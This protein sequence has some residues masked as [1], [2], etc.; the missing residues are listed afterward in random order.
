MSRKAFET[1]A[2]N[3]HGFTF[4][5]A[6]KVHMTRIQSFCKLKMLRHAQIQIV[7]S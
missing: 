4:L 5:E 6:M 2:Q 1:N 3:E 7:A